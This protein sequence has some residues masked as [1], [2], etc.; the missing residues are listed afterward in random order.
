MIGKSVSN[1]ISQDELNKIL[2]TLDKF[3][4]MSIINYHK[5]DSKYCV[6]VQSGIT[7]LKV[8]MDELFKRT[9]QFEG[10]SLDSKLTFEESNRRK[11]LDELMDEITIKTFWDYTHHCKTF[12]DFKYQMNILQR[13]T[14][15]SMGYKIKIYSGTAEDHE[16]EFGSTMDK[17]PKTISWIKAPGFAMIEVVKNDDVT[18]DVICKMSEETRELWG[19]Q[20]RWVNDGNNLKGECIDKIKNKITKL[21]NIDDYYTCRCGI[22]LHPQDLIN[23]RAIHM[24]DC[25]YGKI[26]KCELKKCGEPIMPPGGWLNSDSLLGHPIKYEEDAYK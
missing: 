2:E 1:P 18:E 15:K 20:N 23:L 16:F 22:E 9:H 24:E 4:A 17:L 13:I 25:K 6:G 11:N 10:Y 21:I 14:R 7:I 5:D 8:Y 3:C 12:K 19:K 26:I